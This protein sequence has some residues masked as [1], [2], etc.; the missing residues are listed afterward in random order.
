GVVDGAMGI[1]QPVRLRGNRACGRRASARHSPDVSGAIDQARSAIQRGICGAGMRGRTIG[2]MFG[3]ERGR[4]DIGRCHREGDRARGVWA[5]RGSWRITRKAL[6]AW[7]G[8]WDDID[9]RRGAAAMWADGAIAFDEGIL[10]GLLISR[11]VADCEE[12]AAEGDFVAA[13]AVGEKA[14]V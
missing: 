4:G 1:M 9:A 13:S 8:S 7:A 6:V 10:A 12:L 2:G 3:D 5:G 14:V 11:S